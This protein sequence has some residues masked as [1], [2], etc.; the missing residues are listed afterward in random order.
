MIP[1]STGGE[2]VAAGF[3][4]EKSGVLPILLPRRNSRGTTLLTESKARAA[5]RDAVAVH[6][7]AGPQQAG[8]GPAA[9]LCLL[10]AGGQPA[11]PPVGG[12]LLVVA[13]VQSPALPYRPLPRPHRLGGVSGAPAGCPTPTL[14]SYLREADAFVTM[15]EHEG[16]WRALG[17]G[18]GHGVPAFA[19][20][21]AAIPTPW[22]AAGGCL[23][24]RT[25][26]TWRR[27]WRRSCATKPS[28][29]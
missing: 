29:A 27:H 4:E 25:G 1:T 13:G 14:T 17:G 20:G 8:G 21:A 12:G 16:F 18:R 3:A 9:L 11:F 22:P 15:S 6:R 28:G 26:R 24:V 23:P 19:Y 2:L 7:P 5:A 10:P